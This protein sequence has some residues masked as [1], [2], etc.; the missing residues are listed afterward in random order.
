MAAVAVAGAASAQVT[1]TGGIAYGWQSSTEVVDA[2]SRAERAG[3]GVDTSSVTFAASEDLGGGMSVSGSMTIGGI[4]RSSSIT[5]ENYAMTLNAGSMGSFSFQNVESGSGIRGIGSAGAPVN[6]M[7]GEI[8][9]AAANINVA[10]YTLP[11]MI[12]GVALSVNH[13]S[14]NT[15]MGAGDSNGDSTS[16]GIAVDY[17]AGALTAK[18]DYTNYQVNSAG[19]TS[20]TRI[21]ASYD[22]GMATVGFGSELS[23]VSVCETNRGT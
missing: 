13:V 22:M 6:N 8:L 1:I 23:D 14:G 16:N 5:G 3:F 19:Y 2:D 10:K 7:E 20:K 15:G 21:A 17:A 12:D 18:V 9:G 4:N 11:A